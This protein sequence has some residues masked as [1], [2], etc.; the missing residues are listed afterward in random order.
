MFDKE[1]EIVNADFIKRKDV[2]N[3]CIGGRGGKHS[4]IKVETIEIDGVVH[5]KPASYWSNVSGIK[6][7]TIIHRKRK[8]MDDYSAVFTPLRKN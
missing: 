8:G 1:R 7:D 4:L 5:T 2:Y 3:E 6:K